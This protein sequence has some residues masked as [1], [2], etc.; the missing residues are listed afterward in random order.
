[1]ILNQRKQPRQ[2][3]SQATID[4]IIEA[5]AQLISAQGLT[6]FNTNAVAERAGLSIGS[7]YQY[8]PNKDAI[9]AALIRRTQDERA[10]ALRSALA[11]PY[12]SLDDL[13]RAVVHA[14][15]R[16]NREQSL[17]AAVI[18]LEEARLPV[19]DEIDGYLDATGSAL[20]E[21]FARYPTELA[22]VDPARAARTLPALVRSVIDSW[23]NLD[24]PQ[25]QVAEEE[26]IRAVCG[27]LGLTRT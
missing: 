9:M 21:V 27:Y 13:V 18:D 7:L 25:P 17:L 16:Q 2:A 11:E 1:M 6:G 19:A 26:A 20:G 8:F 3:R 14:V 12:R 23:A 10:T 4:A 15:N 24:P 5:A 22:C